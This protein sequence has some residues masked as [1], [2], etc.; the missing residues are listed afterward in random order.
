V[1]EVIKIG[2][3]KVSG[4]NISRKYIFRFY[5]WLQR[6]RVWYRKFQISLLSFAK[7]AVLYDAQS[8]TVLYYV[9]KAWVGR[10][11]TWTIRTVPSDM[12]SRS[13]VVSRAGVFGSGQVGLKLSKYFG[14][15]YKTFYNIQNN[16]IFL[17]W[18]TFTG[19]TAVASV[20]E[21]IVIFLQL[22]LFA[23]TAAF[24]CSPLRLV[25]HPFWEGGQRWGI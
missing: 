5:F 8:A 17:S 12:L 4:R 15:A 16:G 1:S 9:C 25:S 2:R 20:S 23:N 24:F 6:V 11:G 18:R 19:F 7:Q 21:V 13:R 10:N 14:P 22:I 3:W